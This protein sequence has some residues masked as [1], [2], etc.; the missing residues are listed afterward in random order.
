MRAIKIDK[1]IATFFFKKDTIF[2]QAT[3]AIGAPKPVW[4]EW[5]VAG[6]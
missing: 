1:V 6:V 2:I 5:L 3:I 4:Q